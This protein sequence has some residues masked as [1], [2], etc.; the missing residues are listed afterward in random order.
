VITNQAFVNP[1]P[2]AGSDINNND[3]TNN[4]T[5]TNMQLTQDSVDTAIDQD[6]NLKR[7]R[8]EYTSGDEELVLNVSEGIEEKCWS[9]TT[10]RH[11][12]SYVPNQIGGLSTCERKVLRRKTL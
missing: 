4:C 2:Y 9:D 8:E 3:L 11:C 5:L 7:V 1:S 12:G 10:Q 6:T